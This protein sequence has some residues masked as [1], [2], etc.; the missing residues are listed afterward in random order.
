ML[1]TIREYG[2]E[3][4]EANGETTAMCRRH[5]DWYL[6]L[7]ERAAGELRGPR[8]A[9]WF[10]HFER[11]HANLRAALEWTMAQTDDAEAGADLVEALAWFWVLRGHLRE[12]RPGGGVA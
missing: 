12:A 2:L 3:Q 1:G 9:A 10:S 7:A 11:E 5:R 8:Q 4:L 6:G